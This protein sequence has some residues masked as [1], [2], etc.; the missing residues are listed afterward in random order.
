MTISSQ[1]S[2]DVFLRRKSDAV[3][4]LGPAGATWATE[5]ANPQVC[6]SR[7]MLLAGYKCG[8]PLKTH[9]AACPDYRECSSEMQRLWRANLRG[10]LLGGAA[11]LLCRFYAEEGIHTVGRY[12]E[13]LLAS[14]DGSFVWTEE[15]FD[16]I[17]SVTQNLE[18]HN[19]KK[20]VARGGLFFGDAFLQ[21]ARKN[22]A[23][24]QTA[25]LSAATVLENETCR[26]FCDIYDVISKVSSL[27][28]TNGI[29]VVRILYKMRMQLHVSW[30]AVVLTP[31]CWTLVRNMNENS[32]SGPFD[33]I[34]V[35]SLQDGVRM[36]DAVLDA[37]KDG[38]TSS[39]TRAIY[40]NIQVW[41]LSIG[42][43]E[44]HSCTAEV[45]K[46]VS[47][48]LPAFV[49]SRLP[50]S[51]KEQLKMRLMLKGRAAADPNYKTGLD[52][53]YGKRLAPILVDF[54]ILQDSAWSQFEAGTLQ[55]GLA[56]TYC[57]CRRRMPSPC[58]K[59]RRFSEK[60][61]HRADKR[62][63]RAKK[64][65]NDAA[66]SAGDVLEANSASTRPQEDR[67]D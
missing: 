22:V 37:F 7:T 33:D 14:D 56:R 59:F 9:L 3:E 67:A 34:A 28:S 18:K 35:H 46:K 43:C 45:G 20:M 65:Q 48:N 47:D 50:A 66:D 25:A 39:S 15:H 17:G 2:L 13:Q 29:Q 27:K 10:P 64:A 8:F 1:G 57:T 44:S 49:L 36:H 60:C 61:N 12:C 16:G 55:M 23:Q 63:R 31:R 53:S 4:D 52:S 54:P 40:N 19:R 11:V 26:A 41:E 5:H 38:L 24:F 6:I 62:P 30:P 58:R 32:A 51:S 42:V 21:H